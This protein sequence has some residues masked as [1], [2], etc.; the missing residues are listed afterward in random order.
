MCGLFCCYFLVVRQLAYKSVFYIEVVYAL[1]LL[2]QKGVTMYCSTFYQCDILA[3]YHCDLG[4]SFH[5]IVL[6]SI[7]FF[8]WVSIQQPMFCTI[9]TWVFIET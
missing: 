3:N 5:V 1:A 6:S 8:F 2:T 7:L 4:A 9:L